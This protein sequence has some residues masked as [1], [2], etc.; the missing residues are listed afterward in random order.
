[1]RLLYL[2]KFRFVDALNSCSALER[3][4]LRFHDFRPRQRAFNVC[5]YPTHQRHTL[6]CPSEKKKEIIPL[7]ILCETGAVS[8]A[9]PRAQ[10]GLSTRH[11]AWLKATLDSRSSRRNSLCGLPQSGYW[12]ILTLSLVLRNTPAPFFWFLSPFITT[13][14]IRYLAVVLFRGMECPLQLPKQISC[15]WR[16]RGQINGK[17]KWSWQQEGNKKRVGEGNRGV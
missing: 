2:S 11:L 12:H 15:T 6:I 5:I 10:L 8:D 13:T 4:N 14:F 3:H 17:W 9:I 16:A 1:M 7:L